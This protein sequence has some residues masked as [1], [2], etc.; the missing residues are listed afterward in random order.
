MKHFIEFV[1]AILCETKH[2]PISIASKINV[3]KNKKPA[4]EEKKEGDIAC[5]LYAHTTTLIYF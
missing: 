3:F 5:K 4:R 2:K 1:G